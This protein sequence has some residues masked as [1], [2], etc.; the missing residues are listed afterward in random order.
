MGAYTMYWAHTVCTN[1]INRQIHNVQLGVAK[2]IAHAATLVLCLLEVYI[3][4]A[5]AVDINFAGSE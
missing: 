2:C 3:V 5:H 4:H 1:E